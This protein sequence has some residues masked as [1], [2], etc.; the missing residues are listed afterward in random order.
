MISLAKNGSTHSLF[1]LKSLKYF[2]S[3]MQCYFFFR[4]VESAYAQGHTQFSI[5]E[6]KNEKEEEE[7]R[8]K[9]THKH[10]HTNTHKHTYTL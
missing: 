6:Y 1:E 2:I 3:E 4:C 7:E 9:N 8:R 10:N 5:N